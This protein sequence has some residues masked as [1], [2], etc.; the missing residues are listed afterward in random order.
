MNKI[1]QYISWATIISA[2]VLILTILYW[3][4]KPYKPVTFPDKPQPVSTKIVKRG[5]TLIYEV[6]FCK[7]TDEL[8]LI[9]KTFTDGIIFPIP[10]FISIKNEKGCHVNTVSMSVPESLPT[11][12]YV[13]TTV[14]RYQV[15]PIR[16]IDVVTKTE[17]F[18][19]IE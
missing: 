9:T 13:L 8:P 5:G 2:L 12:T 10:S 19:I 11:G 18:T 3:L 16:F 6:E 7:Y 1:F 15:N 4:I 17:P 14:Y